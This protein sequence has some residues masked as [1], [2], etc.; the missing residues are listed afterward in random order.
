MIIFAKDVLNKNPKAKIIGD[1]KCSK[2][3]YE[4]IEKMGGIPIMWK[5]GHSLIKKKMKEKGALLAGEMS[6]H[7]FFN[8]RYFGFDDAIYASLRLAEILKK[9]GK[10]YSLTKLLKGIRNTYTSPE[11]RI[12]CPDE[13]KFEIVEKFKSFFNSYDCCTIDGIRI[14]FP[15]GWALLRASNTQP[16]VVIRFEAETE[17]DMKKIKE[18]IHQRLFEVFQFF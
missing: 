6:G 12:F 8:D 9:S 7:I 18:L 5:T 13:K 16:A 10:P 14:N 1:V 3:M 11:I 15:K 4:E 2:I 17:E